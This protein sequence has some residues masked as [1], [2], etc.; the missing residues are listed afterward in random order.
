MS[1]TGPH[2]TPPKPETTEI[3]HQ[4]HKEETRTHKKLLTKLEPVNKSNVK[5]QEKHLEV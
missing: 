5:N 3:T 1:Q 2:Q 4:H